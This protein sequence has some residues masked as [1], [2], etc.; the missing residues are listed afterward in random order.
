MCGGVGVAVGVE[1]GREAGGYSR[2]V[3]GSVHFP[4]HCQLW[5]LHHRAAVL[6]CI[7]MY[8]I[9]WKKRWRFSND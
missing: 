4:V 1:V 8:S 9:Q 5:R 2:G 3:G 7:R 6:S